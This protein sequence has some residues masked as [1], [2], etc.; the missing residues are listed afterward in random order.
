MIAKQELV[1]KIK[2]YF[3]LNI[4]ETKVWM[5]LLAKGIVTAGETAEMSGVPRS[6]TYDV[7]ESLEKRGFAIVRLGKPIKYIAVEPNT[8]LEKMK[9]NTMHD[10]Q[11]KV[12]SLVNLKG[13]QEYVELE[14]LHKS[15]MSPIK[16][17]DITGFLKGRASINSKI[18][19]LLE[20]VKSEVAVYTSLQDFEKKS[21]II[22]PAIEKLSKKNVKVKLAFS[23]SPDEVKK[24]SDKSGIRARHAEHKGRFFMFDKSDVLFMISPESAEEE[25]GIWLKAPF[26]T[27][28]IDNIFEHHFKR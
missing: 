17:E 28:S 27:E 18:R 24:F 25:I 6:R 1:K 10:A 21:K 22:L 3:D 5:A 12:K 26:F 8:I 14:Q 16:S 7:L 2:D 11:E 4:Y 9:L 19:E 20:N 13:T 15:G 23:G